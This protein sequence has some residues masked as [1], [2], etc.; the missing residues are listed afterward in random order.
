[1]VLFPHLLMNVTQPIARQ[2]AEEAA[3]LWLLRHN[4]VR[5]PH[6]SVSDL[7][8]LDSRIEAH[9]DGLRIAGDVGW[10]ICMEALRLEG[11]GEVFAAAV[12]AFESGDEKRINDV[13]AV[14]MASRE[15]TRGIISALG[16]MPL[17]Q[18]QPYLNRFLAPDSPGFH[19]IGIAGYAVHRQDPG[20]SLKNAL[21]DTDA[22]LKALALK[23][24]GELGRRD[25]LRA[26]Q[27]HLASDDAAVVFQAA[28]LAA[29]LGD[30]SGVPALKRLADNGGPYVERAGVMAL[31]RMS[32][33]EGHA[34]QRHLTGRPQSQ[35]LSVQAAG[36]IG[37]PALIPWLIEQ[38]A[39][40]PVARVAGE[41]FTMITGVDLTYHDLEEKCPEGF[42]AGPTEE[43]D[44]ENVEMD[45][46]EDLPW[47][48]PELI[49]KWCAKH[50]GDFRNGVRHLLGKPITDEWLWQVLKVGKQR[51]RAAAAM[52]LAML[53][54]GRPLF[55]VKAPGFRQLELLAS[56]STS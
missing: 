24:V 6:Y 55:N 9:I 50:R 26:V 20:P 7:V 53:Q 45:P 42:Q 2:Y 14:G 43:P 40:P 27:A 21:S 19:H 1:L 16:W 33:G 48:N 34:W 47:P 36:V 23:A 38:M 8:K 54:P 51:Q 13:L 30:G 29:L 52:E 35:R 22:P 39:I 5:S 37:D 3:F 4:A 28:W 12:L 15:L 56:M 17:A 41:A 49:Q 18:G 44:D 25:L 10:E 11:P 32:L 31:R 46:D